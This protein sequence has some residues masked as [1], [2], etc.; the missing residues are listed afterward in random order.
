MFEFTSFDLGLW[1]WV[2]LVICALLV[3]ISKTGV[4]GFSILVV[5]MMA[6]VLPAK[7]SVGVLLPMLIFADIFAVIYHRYNAKWKHIIK[8]IP[9]SLVGIIAGFL[10]MGKISD[11]QLK[12]IIG[13]IVLIMLALRYKDAFKK[14]NELK[15]P[16]HWAFAASM[17]F[18]AGLTTMMANAAGPVMTIYLLAMG[19]PKKKF[20]GTAAWYFFLI[21]WIKVPFSSRL[22]LITSESLKLDL[23]LFPA[24][25]AGAFIGIFLLNKIPQKA[26][27]I[28]VLI[29]ATAAA[30]KLII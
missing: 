29:L 17:G 16:S 21:N 14:D 26:F 22:Q 7:V 27:K 1:H 10:L 15:I 9:A 2:V 8:L 30:I 20:V 19:L 3:G 18:F 13:I 6:S 23:C 24:I 25:A 12:P 28:I 5:P 11:A 4:P